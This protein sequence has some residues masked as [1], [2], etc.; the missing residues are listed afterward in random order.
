MNAF[1]RCVNAVHCSA[2]NASEKDKRDF[3]NELVILKQ[4][5]KHP[6]VVCLVGACHIRGESISNVCVYVCVCV[7]VC[8]CVSVCVCVKCVCV[9]VCVCACVRA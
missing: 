7:C 4:V 5:G 6:N 9:C 3:L 1:K 8:V 2:E